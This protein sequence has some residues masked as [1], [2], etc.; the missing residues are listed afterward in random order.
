MQEEVASEEAEAALV[1]VQEEVL[2]EAAALA[3]VSAAAA[4]AAAELA[5]VGN[6]AKLICQLKELRCFHFRD[7]SFPFVI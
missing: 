1:A 5:V 4:L 6:Q 2:A 7:L 3:V